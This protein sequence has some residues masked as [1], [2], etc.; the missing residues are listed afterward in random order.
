MAGRWGSGRGLPSPAKFGEKARDD[1]VAAPPAA[2]TRVRLGPHSVHNVVNTWIIATGAPRSLDGA[3][4]V[5]RS[6]VSRNDVGGGGHRIRID[7][8]NSFLP[9]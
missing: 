5:Q 9:V 3:A 6:A 8:P 7:G 4:A 2:P 1:L